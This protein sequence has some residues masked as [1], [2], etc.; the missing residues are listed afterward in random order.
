MLVEEKYV[1]FVRKTTELETGMKFDYDKKQ[2][3]I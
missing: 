3:R 2:F 1:R